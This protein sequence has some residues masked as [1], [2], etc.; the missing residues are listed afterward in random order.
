MPTATQ[1]Q[2]GTWTINGLKWVKETGTVK[3]IPD[4]LVFTGTISYNNKDAVQVNVEKNGTNYQTDW[5]TMLGS[6]LDVNL[7]VLQCGD[8]TRNID[9]KWYTYK[10]K[11][12]F[13]AEDIHPFE[14]ELNATCT[15][16]TP[17]SDGD[18]ATL[19]ITANTS[20]SVECDDWITISPTEGTSGV[21]QAQVT[22]SENTGTDTRTG[23]ISVY[24]GDIY[25][26]I[27]IEQSGFVPEISITSPSSIES[28]STTISYTAG[29]NIGG[30]I[31]ELYKDGVRQDAQSTSSS[32][33]I[34]SFSV[35]PNTSLSSV[36]YTLKA[37][38]SEYESCTASTTVT[39]QGAPYVFDVVPT[40]FTFTSDGT[41]Q[42]LRIN[43]PNGYS[44]E[45][46]NIPAWVYAGQTGGSNNAYITVSC[47]TNS[48]TDQRSTNN[49][50]VTDTTNSRS[51]AVTITQAGSTPPHPQEI[52]V[53]PTSIV[54]DTTGGTTALT[55]T[56]EGGYNWEI[57]D[58]PEGG[59]LNLSQLNGNTS[60]VLTVTCGRNEE[61]PKRKALFKLMNRDTGN[62]TEITC[63]QDSDYV[64]V[65]VRMKTN[66]DFDCDDF[67]LRITDRDNHMVSEYEIQFDK[68]DPATWDDSAVK[69]YIPLALSGETYYLQ[70]QTCCDSPDNDCG[71]AGQTVKAYYGKQYDYAIIGQ[72][73][74][75]TFTNCQN[76]ENVCSFTVTELYDPVKCGSN[77]GKIFCETFV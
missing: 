67:A 14:V 64:E 45:I 7:L 31:V 2:D 60:V 3:P 65:D 4:D 9:D 34:S 51:S 26:D 72:Q 77:P 40:S 58:L 59:W 13:T 66:G 42:N 25:V 28:T 33:L 35:S 19:N 49:I 43:D 76:W 75:H 30:I 73:S 68:G 22:Y 71:N 57:T 50:T 39:Q 56:D 8:V 12:N 46:T 24:A 61:K 32:E 17:G 11:S 36:T 29:T 37:I 38:C 54:F 5:K 52:T 10:A 62:Y 15:N 53:S 18:S 16:T 21:T 74:L 47:D 41:A 63:E 20:W 6:K 48:S 55:I 70:N 69:A 23:R 27:S 1:N 44:W